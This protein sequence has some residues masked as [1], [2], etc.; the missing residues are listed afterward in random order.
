[1]PNLF[2]KVTCSIWLNKLV[3]YSELIFKILNSL[4]KM[5]REKNMQGKRSLTQGEFHVV[6]A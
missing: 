6:Y 5:Y 1:M 2:Y 3:I 4:L